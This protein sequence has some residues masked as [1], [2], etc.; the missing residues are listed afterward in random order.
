MATRD[1]PNG[2][3]RPER[4]RI[5]PHAGV[6]WNWVVAAVCLGLIAWFRASDGSRLAATI[7]ATLA[8]AAGLLALSPRPTRRRTSP[9]A[10]AA[11]PERPT[12]TEVERTLEAY[13]SRTRS[14]LVITIVGWAVAVAGIF[15]FPPLALVAAAASAYGILRYRRYKTDCETLYRA[16]DREKSRRPPP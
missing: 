11:G 2:D 9:R 15:V 5:I 14:W 7:F 1:R 3:R 13:G 8:V 4:L 12:R 10:T 16:L 6:R